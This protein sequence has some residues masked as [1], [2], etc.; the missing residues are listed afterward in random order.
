MADKVYKLIFTKDDGSED[1]VQFT[2]PQGEKGEPGEKGDK[3]DPGEQGEQGIQGIPGEK[4]DKGDTGA[5]GPAGPAG[6]TY[7]LTDEDKTEM[8][9]S[10]LAALPTWNGGNY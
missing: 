5:T 3:G 1:V 6:P 2:A 4:G 7:T 10:V 9:N 8:V